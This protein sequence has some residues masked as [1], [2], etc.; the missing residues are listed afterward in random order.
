MEIKAYMFARGIRI[1]KQYG[2]RE[3]W[4]RFV[5]KMKPEDVPYEKWYAK[6]KIKPEEMEAQKQDSK[7][8]ENRPLIS[9][10]VPLYNTPENYLIQMIDSVVGQTYT[11]W[12]LCLADGSPEETIEDIIKRHY[13]EENR[14]LYKHLGENLGIAGNTNAAFALA[15]GQWIALLD[16]DDILAPEA[17]YEMMNAAGINKTNASLVKRN[18]G[19]GEADVVYSDEDKVSEDLKKYFKPHFKPDFNIMLLRSNNYITHF[20]A[21]K[22]EIVEKVGGFRSEY[23]G[24]Q[25][26]DFILRC[27]EEAKK[28]AHVPRPIYHWRVSKNSTAENPESKMYCF[29]S[30]RKAVM[31]HLERQGIKGTVEHTKSLGFY[32]A[33]YELDENALI[34]I[35]IPNKDEVETLKC[36]LKSLEKST[37]KNF[38][39]IIVENNSTDE[40]TFEYYETLTSK[41]Y[42][43]DEVLEGS[44][45][46]GNALKIVT[47]KGEFNYSAINN[48]GI[49]HAKGEYIVFLN[50]DIEIITEDW[51]EEMLGHCQQKGVGAVGC[52]LL[53]SDNTIQHAGV[54][55]GIGG[56]ANSVFIGMNARHY[57][58]MHRASLQSNYSAVTAACMMVKRCAFEAVDGLTEELKVAFNDIDFCLKLAEKGYSIVYTPY[59]MA[60]HYESKSRGKEDTP[61]KKARFASEVQYMQEH[62]SDILENGDPYYNPNLSLKKTDYSI[63]KI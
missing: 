23:E 5:E 4:V 21:V 43:K 1:W 36:C 50:N 14:I 54:V 61:E 35:V 53:Y 11:N 38:E 55:V 60:Y 6:K 31:A 33:K 52:K 24:S 26:H 12:Q 2:F 16:H 39:V 17:L 41:K 56:V 48:F 63:G 27:T 40:K 37:Y 59:A 10:C 22:R 7:Q 15:T 30:G 62:W 18:Y 45:K 32:R 46:T 49:K 3:L 47:W 34:S 19:I 51:L 29:E 8:W 44:L 13:P 9:I 58:Y 20:F 28:I 42:N 25:D 57:G